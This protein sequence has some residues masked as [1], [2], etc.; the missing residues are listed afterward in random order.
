MA[1]TTTSP[2]STGT[3]HVPCLVPPTRFLRIP[4][5][6]LTSEQTEMLSQF[7]QQLPDLIAR[8][9][10][11]DQAKHQRFC[12]RPCLLRY[13]RANKWV[14]AK[15]QMGLEKT[16]QWRSEYRPDEITPDE[17]EHESIKG[18]MYVN[19]YDLFG[20]A[21]VYMRQRLNHT[22]EAKSQ[23]R[24][25][26]FTLERAVQIL[27]QTPDETPESLTLVIDCEGWSMSNSVPL[28]TA[29]E[30][31]HILGAHY[32]ERLGVALIL[33]AP[34]LFWTFFKL[35]SPFIDP[36][37]RKKIQFVDLNTQQ[38][39]PLHSFSSFETITYDP[40]AHTGVATKTTEG[41]TM[42]KTDSAASSPS[43]SDLAAQLVARNQG[44]DNVPFAQTL[45]DVAAEANKAAA[46]KKAKNN[47]IWTNLRNHFSNDYL[48]HTIGGAL[49]FDYL[50]KESWP[51]YRYLYEQGRQA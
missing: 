16:L 37:T 1:P 19:G 36:V 21:V 33:N 45:S 11:Q 7:E 51:Y 42:N 46:K 17:I 49:S 48:E 25:L 23:M 40:R 44:R 50:H 39:I 47:E 31:L 35:V 26:V 29:R 30:T 9:P 41:G 18:K 13:L 6:P 4:R 24:H 28:G 38:S 22:N 43:V 8:L 15:A 3:S 27:P 32:P 12:T 2:E 10:E 34:W 5:D 20:R 14:L